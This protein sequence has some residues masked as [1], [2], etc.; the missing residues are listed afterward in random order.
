MPQTHP[1]DERITQLE[2]KLAF[3][4]DLLDTLNA[5]VARQQ[6]QIELLA[7]ELVRLRRRQHGDDPES[8]AGPTDE[9]PPHY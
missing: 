3:A 4:E 2:V 6:E 7:R 1:A 5:T 8:L 9:R